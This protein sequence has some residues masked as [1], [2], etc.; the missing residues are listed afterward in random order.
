MDNQHMAKWWGLNSNQKEARKLI[1]GPSPPG[2]CPLTGHNPELLSS[3]LLDLT[4]SEDI[5]T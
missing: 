2:Y 5:S 3:S 1:L 4:P